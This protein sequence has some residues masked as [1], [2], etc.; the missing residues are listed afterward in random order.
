MV[1]IDYEGQMVFEECLDLKFPYTYLTCEKKFRKNLSQETCPDGDETRT[2][3]LKSVN[4]TPRLQLRTMVLCWA[5]TYTIVL[6]RSLEKEKRSYHTKTRDEI[7]FANF[8]YDRF[9]KKLFEHKFR[10]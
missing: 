6:Q 10:N 1:E 7:Y 3:Y 2:R 4:A 5:K 9:Y 8:K